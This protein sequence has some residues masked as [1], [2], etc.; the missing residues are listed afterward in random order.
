[1]SKLA[2]LVLIG[3]VAILVSGLVGCVS[4]PANPISVPTPVIDDDI[5]QRLVDKTWISPAMV[6]IGAPMTFL[7]VGIDSNT[8]EIYVQSTK[9]FPDSGFVL[10][11]NET[12][13]YKKTTSTSF[14]DSKV[15]QIHKKGAV[16]LGAKGDYYPGARAEWDL[17]IHNGNDAVQV[18]EEYSVL[19]GA[20]EASV[21]IQLKRPL[22]DADIKNVTL[23]GN[24]TLEK[25]VATYYNPDTKGLVIKGLI[26]DSFRIITI[27][28]F[29]WAEFL[30][31]YREPDYAKEGYDR[32]PP[33]AK[34]WVIIV[35]S[36]PVLAPKE[37]REILVVLAM[38]R[39]VLAPPEKHYLY[40]NR[41]EFWVSVTEQTG[42]SVQTEMASRWLV[43]KSVV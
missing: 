27:T 14:V 42:G 34:D 43:W 33:E 24:N 23:F 41:W 7:V 40:P 8:V 20:D 2:A 10:V 12:I 26:P 15:T 37:T 5:E 21:E 36:T 39:M 32:P 19:T 31:S 3:L 28:Y 1:M 9:G 18:T 22:A 11:G 29:A 30:V 4:A 6:S 16:V 25:L 35:D 17:R 38:P 13:P